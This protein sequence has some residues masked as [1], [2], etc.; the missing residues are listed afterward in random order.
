MILASPGDAAARTVIRELADKT[1]RVDPNNPRAHITRAIVMQF[2]G[3]LP[4][5]VISIERALDL[6][7]KSTNEVLYA[8]A[9]QLMLLSGRPA[10]AVRLAR[11]GLAVAQTDR[12]IVIR[13]DLA[14]GLYAL[15]KREEALG[16]LAV[17]LEVQP[18]NLTAQQLR[19]EILRNPSG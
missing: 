1:V 7:P 16:Q 19:A 5:A 12:A 2:L 17:V 6:D 10:D 18:D 14:R 15:G 3:D 4:Q 11:D 8:T 9:T 13:I